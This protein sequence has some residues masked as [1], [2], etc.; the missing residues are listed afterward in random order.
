MKNS[1]LSDRE[2][3]LALSSLLRRD[4]C[5]PGAAEL[6]TQ[7]MQDS[8]FPTRKRAVSIAD[9]FLPHRCVQKALLRIAL[10]SDS[11]M[12][13]RERCLDQ[14]E[15]LFDPN[16]PSVSASDCDEELIYRMKRKLVELMRDPSESMHLRGTAL[17]LCAYFLSGEAFQKWILFFHNRT[18]KS[19]RLFAISAMGHS[20]NARW[21][22]YLRGFLESDDMDFTCAALEAVAEL[23]YQPED[24]IARETPNDSSSDDAYD[25]PGLGN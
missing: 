14:L 9:R 22:N 1:N 3:Q 4:S 2:K 8:D 13:L 19:C 20:G 25:P 24:L 7:M 15:P 10:K 16:T 21:R 5:D 18:R 17:R 12:I 6:L 11:R 23:D